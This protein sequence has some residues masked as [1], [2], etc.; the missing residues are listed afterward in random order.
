MDGTADGLY[1]SSAY[2]DGLRCNSDKVISQR[3][4]QATAMRELSLNTL[5]AFR[6]RG[7]LGNE[8][9]GSL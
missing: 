9:G 8:V 7:A 5:E 3:C 2:T 1:I 4:W 6:H